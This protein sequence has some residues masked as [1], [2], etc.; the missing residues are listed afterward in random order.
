MGPDDLDHPGERA[1][2]QADGGLRAQGLRQGGKAPEVG[3]QDNHLPFLS[4]QAAGRFGPAQ[5]FPGDAFVH[6][7]PEGIA[8]QVPFLKPRHHV[9]EAAGELAD[10]VPGRDRQGLTILPGGHLGGLR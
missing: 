10:L 6:V 7:T 4:P 3:E 9:V 1:I 5:Q 8:D 2:D